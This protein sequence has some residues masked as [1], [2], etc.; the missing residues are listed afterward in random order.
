MFC[1][2]WAS[3]AP[4][5]SRASLATS[6]SWLRPTT[7]SPPRTSSARRS[8]GASAGS[9]RRPATST[10]SSAGSSPGPCN[11]QLRTYRAEVVPWP[12]FLTRTTD[13]RIFQNQSTPDII[14]TI[15]EDFGFTDFA[16]ELKGSYPKREYCVQYRETAFNFVS[17]LMEHE[18]IF[19][20]FRHEDGKHTLVLA[21]AVSA[22][23]ECPESP[24]EYSPGSLAPNHVA[25]LGAPVRVPL[26][27]VDPDRLQLRDAQH[28]PAD[29]DRAR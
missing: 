3:R 27:Q 19:Y 9:T 2:F 14:E 15:F 10:G 8:P 24:V 20:F 12:W 6:S 25:E 21:D 26:G 18:G 17:R 29:D 23:A 13:C 28:Q 5:R 4:S 16:L 11:R 7:R 22:Y 1:C